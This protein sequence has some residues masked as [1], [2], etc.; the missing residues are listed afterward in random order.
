[1]WFMKFVE[2][3]ASLFNDWWCVVD[4]EEGRKT[5]RVAAMAAAATQGEAPPPPLTR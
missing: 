4:R 2:T 5:A 1:M 3:K